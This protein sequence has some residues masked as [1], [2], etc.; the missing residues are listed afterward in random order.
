MLSNDDSATEIDA[1][2]VALGNPRRRAI[3]DTLSFRPATVSQLAAEHHLSLAAIHRHIRVLEEANI[4]ER[5]KVGRVNFVAL[6]RRALRAAQA[7]MSQYH[8]EWGNDAETLENYIEQLNRH[9]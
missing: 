4:I 8:L 5:R 7:W 2:F 1:V 6:K 9:K 3:V